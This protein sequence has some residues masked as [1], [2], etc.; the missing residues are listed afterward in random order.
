MQISQ[1]SKEEQ[2]LKESQQKLR[3]ERKLKKLYIGNLH[4]NVTE[5]DLIKVFGLEMT[6]YLWDTFRINL[7]ISKGT[8]KHSSFAFITSP[9]PVYD[10]L[11]KLNCVKFKGRSIVVETAK[12][13]S[14]HQ[15][16]ATQNEA[17]TEF[18]H[19]PKK[20]IALFSDSVTRGIKFK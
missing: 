4:E 19:Q 18:F 2:Q 16:Q 1:H 3:L 17:N 12:T 9:D 13:R 6:Q 14:A 8:G 5:K 10:E 11:L 7:V 15:N 20:N